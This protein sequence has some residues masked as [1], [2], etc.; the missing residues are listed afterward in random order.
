MVFRRDKQ[1]PEATEL[2]ANMLQFSSNIT[3][4]KDRKLV[5]GALLPK[6]KDKFT[7]TFLGEE[8]ELLSFKINVAT[9]REP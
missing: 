9:P 2:T 4:R 5:L 8:K 7:L 1:A 3:G 6:T